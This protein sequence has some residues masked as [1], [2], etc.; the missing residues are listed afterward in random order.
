MLQV[1]G[2]LLLTSQKRKALWDLVLDKR[3][4]SCGRSPAIAW[5]TTCT[6]S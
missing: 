5:V 2:D 6:G 4:V 3:F 1:L